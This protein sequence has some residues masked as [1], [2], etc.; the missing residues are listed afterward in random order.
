MEK[1]VEPM[2][3]LR[4]KFYTSYSKMLDPKRSQSESEEIYKKTFLVQETIPFFSP[5]P[6][7]HVLDR[8][9][10]YVVGV[11][12]SDDQYPMVAISNLN[13]KNLDFNP[14][15]YAASGGFYYYTGGALLMLGKICGLFSLTPGVRYYFTHP[16]ETARM[17]LLLRSIGGISCLLTLAL[18]CFWTQKFLPKT[19]AVVIAAVFLSI[20][21]A[22]YLSHAV[23]AHLYG[24]FLFSVGLFY[25]MKSFESEHKRFL[26]LGPLFLGLAAGSIL[27]NLSLGIAILIV[28]LVRNEWNVLRML[29]GKRFWISTFV[30]AF[31]FSLTNFYIFL[32]IGGFKKTVWALQEYTKGY[33]EYGKINILNW[34]PF[35]VDVLNNQF[36]WSLLPL[37]LLGIV[38]GMRSRQPV[39]KVCSLSFLLLFLLNLLTTRHPGVNARLFPL[40]AILSGFGFYVLYETPSRPRKILVM[41]YLACGLALS[42]LQTV[43]YLRLYREPSLLEQAGEWIDRNIPQGTTVG[44]VGAQFSQAAYPPIRFLNYR[45]VHFPEGDVSVKVREDVLPEIVMTTARHHTLLQSHYVL[46]QEWKKPVKFFSV[47]FQSKWIYSGNIDFFGIYKKINQ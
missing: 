6:Q 26:F 10:G 9:R 22:V 47:P 30:F 29:R 35:L 39:L 42:A 45:L 46:V 15:V 43:Y 37:L 16:E 25:L 12:L 23:K 34:I 17:Y 3:E 11:L 7:E 5:L 24:M 1:W 18:L 21:G 20:P 31:V 27:T 36:H 41:S 4:E 8:I 33:D 32:D 19:V 2:I 44:V 38:W 13:P 14:N 28:E 40:A